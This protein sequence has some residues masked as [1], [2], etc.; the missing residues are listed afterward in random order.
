MGQHVTIRENG[1]ERVVTAAQALLL[2]LTQQGLK[3]GGSI[4]QQLAE[5]LQGQRKLQQGPELDDVLLVRIHGVAPGSVNCALEDLR[6]GWTRDR[7]R[8]TAKM[9]LEPWIVERALNRM[10]DERLTIEQQSE[11]VKATRTP[12]KV[13]WPDWWQ[14]LPE[15]KSKA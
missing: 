6:M 12:K 8:P 7:K 1:E 14:V 3:H 4:A 2:K 15:S 10:G 11:V 9:V 13:K 5:V